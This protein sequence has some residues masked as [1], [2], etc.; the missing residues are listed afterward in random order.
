MRRLVIGCDCVGVDSSCIIG[1]SVLCL[2]RTGC[3]LHFSRA[4]LLPCKRASSLQLLHDCTDIADAFCMRHSYRDWHVD[5][6]AF[7]QQQKQ[8]VASAARLLRCHSALPR[9]SV[10]Y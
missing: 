4:L 1:I 3:S 8:K 5:L 6:K 7:K 10:R 2:L 9:N